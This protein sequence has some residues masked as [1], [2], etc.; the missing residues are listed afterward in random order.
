MF[1]N[2]LWFVVTKNITE[3]FAL[4]QQT[5]HRVKMN[6]T[7]SISLFNLT[8]YTGGPCLVRFLG[9]GKNRTMQNSY[10]WVLHSQFPLVLILL[11]SDQVEIPL[12]LILYL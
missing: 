10:Y 12:V 3:S 7:V 11:H 8:A 1:S 2:L 6:C 9:F 5:T 4:S